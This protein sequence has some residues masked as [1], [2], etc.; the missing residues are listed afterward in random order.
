MRPRIT[1]AGASGV[2]LFVALG[3][4][5]LRSGSVYWVTATSWVLL[6]W[7]SA[8]ILGVAFRRGP[9]R[10]FWSGFAIF[11]WIYMLLIHNSLISTTL[12]DEMGQGLRA[13]VESAWTF[14][15]TAPMNNPVL[16]NAQI[17]ANADLQFRIRVLS[18]LCLNFLFAALGGILAQTFAARTEQERQARRDEPDGGR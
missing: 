10:V 14:R 13:F 2:V 17:R 18:D 3:L 4:A 15:P 5:G 12:A 8:S 11:G 7:L 16:Q 9:A 1:I 6:T